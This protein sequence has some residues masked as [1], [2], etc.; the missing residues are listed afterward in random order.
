M[1]KEQQHSSNWYFEVNDYCKTVAETYDVPLIKVA[2]IMSALS[3]NTTFNQNI[4]SLEAFLRTGGDCKVSTFN[5]Q[6][7]KALKILASSDN[8]TVEE[9]K[10]ILGGLKTQSF[11]DNIFRPEISED[12]TI[13]LWMI[14][15]AGIEGSLTPK[16]Y[17]NVSNKIKDLAKSLNLLPHQV[18]AKI[19][20]DIRGKAW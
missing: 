1:K 20:V 4:R 5:G 18:Q 19:W 6:K 14:R 11:F 7:R 3:P 17:K 12:V 2:G 10:T 9:I 13:D 8:I 16:R 15:W